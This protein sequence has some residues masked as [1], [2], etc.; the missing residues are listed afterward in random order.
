[1]DQLALLKV[2]TNGRYEWEQVFRKHDNFME[3]DALFLLF[4]VSPNLHCHVIWNCNWYKWLPSFTLQQWG[5][6]QHW[7]IQPMHLGCRWA[8]LNWMYMNFATLLTFI[9]VKFYLDV[10]DD[11]GYPFQHCLIN[12]FQTQRG[13][14]KWTT[15]MP[16]SLAISLL[17]LS[18]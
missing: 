5:R 12:N 11:S 16:C 8:K 6:P 7:G 18:F 13:Q 2:C 17:Y 3:V 9:L 4:Y 14:R 1:M 10:L 15:M